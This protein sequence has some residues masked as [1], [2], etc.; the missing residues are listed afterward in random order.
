MGQ[1]IKKLLHAEEVVKITKKY[2]WYLKKNIKGM[3][4]PVLTHTYNIF[5]APAF[6][7]FLLI[8]Y[9]AH[10]LEVHAAETGVPQHFLSMTLLT[11][12]RVVRG[13]L[14]HLHADWKRVL[15]PSDLFHNILER[16]KHQ[17]LKSL[18]SS[19]ETEP[20]SLRVGRDGEGAA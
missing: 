14:W 11:F 17:L 8:L 5:A 16:N 13:D 9:C 6:I 7:F 3:V 15:D 12:C 19:F 20:L 2:G 4:D 10:T 18:D 1:E